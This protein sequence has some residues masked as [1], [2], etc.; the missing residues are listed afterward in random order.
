MRGRGGR[1]PA[2]ARRGRLGATLGVVLGLTAGL[3]GGVEAQAQPRAMAAGAEAT[4]GAVVLRV[5]WRAGQ[6]V[7][8]RV[9]TA[10]TVE[11]ASAARASS[12]VVSVQTVSVGADGTGAQRLRVESLRLGAGTLTAGA[13]GPLVQGLRAA[14]VRFRQDA[15]GAV[16]DTALVGVAEAERARVG[17]LVASLRQLGPTLPVGPLRVGDTWETETRQRFVPGPG[18]ALPLDI[19][20]R[21]TLRALRR[22]DGA[23][24]ADIDTVATARIADGHAVGA[25]P[26]RAE[27]ASTGSVRYDLGR[28]VV[29]DGHERGTLTLELTVRGRP[30]RLR[31]RVESSLRAVPEA[32]VVSS[33]ERPARRH[34]ARRRRP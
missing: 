31:A 30:L 29:L 18:G 1:D 19:Q 32:E 14:E 20:R 28:A 27:G 24:V 23:W 34:R 26:L 10:E 22:S 8:Y 2:R 17:A 12:A 5:G 9:E 7:R 3:G 15:R 16:T 21:Y 11:G 6:T 13:G 33:P 4:D 25:I